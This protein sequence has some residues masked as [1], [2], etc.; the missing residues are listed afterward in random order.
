[1]AASISE[2]FHAVQRGQKATHKRFGEAAISGG[3]LIWKSAGVSI[4]VSEVEIDPSQWV[5]EDRP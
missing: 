1:M 3:I 2:V 4:L 5:I